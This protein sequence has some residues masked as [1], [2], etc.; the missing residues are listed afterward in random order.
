[1]SVLLKIIPLLFIFLLQPFIIYADVIKLKNGRSLEGIVRKE[2]AHSVELEVS[3]GSIKFSRGEVAEILRS[4]K[5]EA[6]S[7]RRQWENSRIELDNKLMSQKAAQ[8]SKPQDVKF[9]H[10]SKGIIV[11]VT[12]NNKAEV[13]MVLDTGASIILLT[14]STAKRIG[15]DLGKLNPDIKVQV[16]D[17]RMVDAARVILSSVIV[18]NS[19]AKRV[20][21]AVLMQERGDFGFGDG[22]LGMSF[23]NNFNFKIDQKEKK[24]ILEKI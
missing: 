1:M 7:L 4:G 12:L 17:G 14:R 22:L 20:P 11:K 3:S 10:D 8:E 6:A 5:S 18:E 24:L 16:A 23:L 19:E 13:P 15:F 2:D 21:A 9:S